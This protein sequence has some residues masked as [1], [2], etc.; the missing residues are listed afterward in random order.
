MF[1]RLD[2][3]SVRGPMFGGSLFLGIDSRIGPVY[4]AY[5]LSEG[6]QRAIYLYIGS[7]IES[8]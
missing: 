2:G 1:K 7:S 4:L 8:F 6:G 3:T 5:G